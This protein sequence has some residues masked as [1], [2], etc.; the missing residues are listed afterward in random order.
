MA[1]DLGAEVVQLR[2]PDPVAALLEFARSHGV[3]DVVLGRTRAPLWQRLLQKA[4]TQRMLDQAEGLDVHIVSFAEPPPA[5]R[6]G[7]RN[8]EAEGQE[9]PG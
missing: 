7:A 4:F 9:V 2:G 5:P 8:G 3:S 1:R 6:D